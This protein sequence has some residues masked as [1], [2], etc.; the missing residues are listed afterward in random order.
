MR[1]R[2][3]RDGNL[4]GDHIRANESQKPLGSKAEIALLLEEYERLYATIPVW[5][6]RLINGLRYEWKAAEAELE[7]WKDGT[8]FAKNEYAALILR[9]NREIDSLRSRI[10]LLE[11]HCK[12]WEK[13][14]N[15]LSEKLDAAEKHV[16]E[17]E[18]DQR[19]M[20]GGQ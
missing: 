20:H 2:P 6:M 18:H 13:D 4:P 14:Y 12:S 7:G 17:L 9:N 19:L 1:E 16:A 3:D 11:Q 8:D 15:S 10:S 5:A